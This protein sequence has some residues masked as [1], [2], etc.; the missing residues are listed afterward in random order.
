MRLGSITT[1]SAGRSAVDRS[2]SQTKEAPLSVGHYFGEELPGL[3]PK[4]MAP[5]LKNHRWTEGRTG[6][7]Q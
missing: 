6:T 3:T 7:G 2:H 4:V 1:P 5:G